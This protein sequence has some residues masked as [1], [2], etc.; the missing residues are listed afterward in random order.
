MHRAVHVH[1]EHA[2]QY[3]VTEVSHTGHVVHDP[4]VVAQHINAAVS[5]CCRL[6]D[7]RALLR[8]R[9]VTLHARDLA[10]G[11]L[12]LGDYLIE[13]RLVPFGRD[14][15]RAL[16]CKQVRHGATHAGASSGNADGPTRGA[17]D[18]DGSCTTCGARACAAP[19][20]YGLGCSR[21]HSRRSTKCSRSSSVNFDGPPWRPP[22][23]RSFASA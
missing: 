6:D 15:L 5:S 2:R 7:L 3:I 23:R 8:L 4:R 12:H 9:N 11:R 16:G 1:A 17:A 19:G 22:C 13:R 10:A 18:R 21:S 20:H 14:N